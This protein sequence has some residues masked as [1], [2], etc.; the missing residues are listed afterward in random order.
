MSDFSQ[1]REAYPDERSLVSALDYIESRL[2][3]AVTPHLAPDH[4]DPTSRTAPEDLGAV[5]HQ[6][7]M[8]Q[9]SQI[10]RAPSL[11]G[12]PPGG[13]AGGGGN[14]S[15]AGDDGSVRSRGV[16][17]SI[18]GNRSQQGGSQNSQNNNNNSQRSRRSDHN[19]Q[20]GDDDST[21]A[22]SIPPAPAFGDL[23]PG[24]SA[25]SGRPR[26]SGGRA[27]FQSGG[28]G[29]AGTTR[30]AAANLRG[31]FAAPVDSPDS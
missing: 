28:V 14:R 31:F 11:N 7:N 2:R 16:P 10:P 29:G 8:S 13:G 20:N 5:V 25:Q 19:S 9:A 4:Q 12:D 21:I 23:G 6:L 1:L 18:G 30:A 15:R 22:S 27:F 24:G 3:E 17:G 26:Q